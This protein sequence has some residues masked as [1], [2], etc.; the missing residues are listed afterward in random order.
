MGTKNLLDNLKRCLPVRAS[1][2]RD[3]SDSTIE[4]RLRAP[5]VVVVI[6]VIV[7]VVAA[8]A[9]VAAA[10]AAAAA[11]VVVA[12]LVKGLVSKL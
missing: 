4:V 9:A 10:R 3:Q 12:K 2:A 1:T 11:S 6:V 8:A 5:V 7:A